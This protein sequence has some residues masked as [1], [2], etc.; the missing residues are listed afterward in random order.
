MLVARAAFAAGDRIYYA[1]APEEAPGAEAAH[2]AFLYSVTPSGRGQ[3]V[4]MEARG[5]SY[6]PAWSPDGRW[7]AYVRMRGADNSIYLFDSVRGR[8]RRLTHGVLPAWAPDNRSLAFVRPVAG[9]P[10]IF[11][12]DIDGKKEEQQLTNSGFNSV[13][14]FSP[15]GQQLAFWSG[16][17]G[18]FG[19]IWKMDREGKN[20]VQ[21]TESKEDA[22]TPDGSSANAPFWLYNARIV[23]W[24]G[25]EQRYGQIWSMN[26]DGS[27][28]RQLTFVEAPASSDNPIWSPNGQ[29]ILFDTQRRGRPE[30][31]I[32]NGDGRKARPLVRHVSVLPARA[33]WRPPRMKER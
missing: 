9:A 11:L 22:Y 1:D 4:A 19:Q 27:D 32:M 16:D 5:G 24:S 23:Y 17:A 26:G 7:L 3:K 15:D 20:R 12:I 21:L 29:Y 25:N 28:K 18:G 13:P 31:W 33:S 2:V 10:Q 8:T 14:T 30:I 6:L